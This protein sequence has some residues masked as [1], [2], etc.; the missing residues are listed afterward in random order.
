M[1]AGTLCSAAT[2]AAQQVYG[3]PSLRAASRISQTAWEPRRLNSST[4][5]SMSSIV[6]P[7]S[8]PSENG[9]N[10]KFEVLFA[11]L[12]LGND[13]CLVVVRRRLAWRL[14]TKVTCEFGMTRMSVSAKIKDG[15]RHPWA[16]RNPRIPSVFWVRKIK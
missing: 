6:K 3:L 11:P 15:L 12:S 2:S 8:K 5:R 16:G 9:V 1:A 7:S 10:D 14:V 4:W 13:D